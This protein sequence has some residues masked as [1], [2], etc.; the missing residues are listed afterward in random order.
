M[1]F[2]N[3]ILKERNY[4]RREISEYSLPGRYTGMSFAI[5]DIEG[6][7]GV[8]ISLCI[9]VGESELNGRISRPVKTAF[10]PEDEIDPQEAIAGARE[11]YSENTDEELLA[12]L[13]NQ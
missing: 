9:I 12:C 7:R 6:R 4:S 13:E 5:R 10:I 3:L 8:Q 1:E 2:G 11:I